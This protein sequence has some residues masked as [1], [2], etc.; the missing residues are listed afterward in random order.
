[1]WVRLPFVTI[2][3][4]GLMLLVC[5]VPTPP[6]GPEKSFIALEFKSSSGKITKDS[7]TDSTGKQ[8]KICMIHNLTQYIDSSFLRIT[9]GTDFNEVHQMRSFK[10]QTDTTYYPIVF[11]APGSYS[12]IFIGYIQ[13][14]AKVLNGTITI[15]DRPQKPV[16][17][18]DTSRPVLTR[19]NPAAENA[20]TNSSSYSISLMCSDSSGLLSLHATL[21]SQT[22]TGV[23]GTG[24]NWTIALSGLVSGS[25]NA[26]VVTA[27]DSSIRANKATLNYAITY[28]PT[29]LDTIGPTITHVSGPASGTTLT[30]PAVEI[31]VNVSDPSIVDSV[32]WIKNSGT[33]RMLTTITGVAGQYLLS[34]TLTDSNVDTLTI[35]AVDKATRH[36]KTTLTLILKYSEPKFTVTY[37]GN[38]NTGGTVQTDTSSY[39]K[40]STVT[41]ATAGTLVK[42]GYTFDGW[43]TAADG[44]GTSFAAGKD[45]FVMLSNVTLFAKW[46]IK[47]YILSYDGNGSNGGIAP[48]EMTFDSNALVTV[49]AN[50][51]LSKTGFDF[52]GWNTKADGNGTVLVAG[53]T[54]RIKSDTTLY[55]QWIVKKYTLTIS[56]PVNGT[57]N[58]SGTVSVDSGAVTT[59]TATPASGFKFKQWS[60]TSGAATIADPAS[61]STTVK[62]TQ[63]NATIQADFVCITFAKELLF[64][65]YAQYSFVD[66]I[67]TEDG[68]YL[69][70]GNTDNGMI[71]VKLNANG[72]T[73][74]T[75]TDNYL[76]SPRSISKAYNGYYM[77]SGYY[78]GTKNIAQITSYVQNGNKLN[79]WILYDTSD[80]S[81]GQTAMSFKDNSYIIGGE[82]GRGY[83][84]AKLDNNRTQ[85]WLKSFDVGL[86]SLGGCM[87]TS[88]GGYIMVG[89]GTAGLSGFVIKTDTNGEEVWRDNFRSS[90][91]LSNYHTH[92]FSSV[93]TTSTGNCTIVGT[94][95]SKGILL[96]VSPSKDV[97]LFKEYNDA[98]KLIS[99]KTTKD[100]SFLIAGST[101]KLGQG[102]SDI[103]IIK[104]NSSGT[105][106]NSAT[107]GTISD[108]DAASLKLTSDGGAIIVGNHWVI[109]TDG[110]GN[111]NQ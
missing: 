70:V 84:L 20:S 3:F 97:Q 9:N 26:I 27:T 75:K 101:E 96:V 46:K 10:G 65:Q 29:M 6:P 58:L 57:V 34:D 82:M 31:I 83:F 78:P 35:V 108:E 19:V 41:I 16:L 8:V 74:W 30:T 72:D 94:T 87:P 61:A 12:V 15:I 45:T 73:V 99:I 23:R 48:A 62:L 63:G 11:S 71:L 67:Q 54:F 49:A 52:N 44:S 102:G 17:D 32:Y 55:A 59:L 14:Q 24:N 66:G 81:Y 42:T 100:G 76:N 5:T 51:T 50:T 38:S 2:L 39:V 91:T 7:I 104:T 60:V 92:S 56:A 36:N 77:I 106:I 22:F 88:D 68:G 4:V 40:G 86:G 109:K 98:T 25:P 47:T 18:G 37:D 89:S 64:S 79:E 69:V 80:N 43:N 21:G 111:V 90:T 13:G 1:M 103:Y 93:D 95:D 85:L 107:Y 28:D 105:I 53:A 33:K 110:N